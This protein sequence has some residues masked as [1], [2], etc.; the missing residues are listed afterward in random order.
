MVGLLQQQPFLLGNDWDL[1]RET[2]RV[3][4]VAINSEILK[5][6]P[7]FFKDIN[8]ITAKQNAKKNVITDAL[9]HTTTSI[10]TKPCLVA[11]LAGYGKTTIISNFFKDLSK[12]KSPQEIAEKYGIS[13]ERAE[14]MYQR[15]PQDI[16]TILIKE[17]KHRNR[18]RTPFIFIGVFNHF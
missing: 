13:P 3:N 12:M 8:A 15:R 18:G 14:T 9:L 1:I 4:R 11:R 10:G 6:N 7:D 16:I 2:L 17:E 5:A